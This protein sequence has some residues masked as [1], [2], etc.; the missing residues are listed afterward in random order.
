MDGSR[1]VRSVEYMVA[2]SLVRICRRGQFLASGQEFEREE[3]DGRIL[4][5]TTTS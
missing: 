1:I 5:E 2:K 4:G 3:E